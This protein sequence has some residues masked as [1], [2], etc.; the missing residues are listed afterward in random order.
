MSS[1][2]RLEAGGIKI[3]TALHHNID[4]LKTELD[5]HGR[6]S[7]QDV[8]EKWEYRGRQAVKNC[9]PRTWRSLLRI[10]S[11]GMNLTGLS[12]QIEDYLQHGG[13]L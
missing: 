13:K 1:L 8:I 4:Y 3:V 10:I 6:L 5:L 9:P 12:Q 2:T 11:Q 7:V